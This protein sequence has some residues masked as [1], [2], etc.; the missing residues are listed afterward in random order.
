MS[1][2][3]KVFK[4]IEFI[5]NSHIVMIHDESKGYAYKRFKDESWGVLSYSLVN[6]FAGLG[7][8]KECLI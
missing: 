6:T 4:A 1:N 3:D 8:K 5:T 7:A 2:Y